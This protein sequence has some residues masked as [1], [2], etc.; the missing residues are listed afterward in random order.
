MAGES[1]YVTRTTLD[2]FEEVKVDGRS[3]LDAHVALQAAIASRCGREVAALFAEPVVTRGNQAA[4]TSITWYGPSDAEPVRLTSLDPETRRGP[5]ATLR[6]QLAE[7]TK[8][9]DD[10]ELGPLIGGALHIGAKDDIFVLD[11]RPL[12]TN[13][14]VVP[15]AATRTQAARDNHFRSTLGDYVALAAAPAVSS[16]A[17]RDRHERIAAAPPPRVPPAAAPAVPAASPPAGAPQPAT[18]ASTGGGEPPP[19]ST[20]L[21]LD[22]PW[23]R[24]PWLPV[25]LAVIVLLLVLAYLALPG[26]LLYPAAPVTLVGGLG[27]DPAVRREINEALQQR[28]DALRQALEQNV[29]SVEGDLLLPG[30]RTPGGMTPLPPEQRGTGPLP[31]APDALVPPPAAAL[32]VPPGSVPNTQSFQGSL[33]DLLDQG[34]ALVVALGEGDNASVGSGFFVAPKTLVTNL[35]VVED[36]RP[37]AIFVT[38]PSLGGLKPARLLYRTPDAQIGRPDFAV[39]EVPEAGNLPNLALTAKLARLDNVVAGGYPTIILDSDLNF[40]ALRNG[41]MGAIPQMAVTQGV[42]TVIQNRGQDLPIV[43]HT[44]S[45]SPGNSGGPLV[46]SC[47]RVVGI[48]TFGRIE[49]EEVNRLNYAIAGDAIAEFLKAN[50]VPHT[51]VDTTCQ[52]QVATAQLAPAPAPAAPSEPAR[53][54]PPE[55]AP[56]PEGGTPPAT[57]P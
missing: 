8:L 34:V 23:Y 29:C 3:V 9:L 24:R 31:F 41:D 15:S 1:F 57:Q 48:N 25:L 22:E 13:W 55:P 45:I 44:A 32:T 18:V 19:P 37:D 42:V 27:E 11:G 51:L 12:L 46:D 49:R 30:G 40:Q 33:V 20:V 36:A 43:I 7:V 2:G 35:H 52:P 21:V 17:W 38:N 56:A 47:G 26:V 4:P 6:A 50:N 5:E 53:E 14:G 28:V 54:A 16:E 10:P 39:L